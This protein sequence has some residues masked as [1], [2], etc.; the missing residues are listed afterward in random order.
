GKY[1]LVET[2]SL[3][4][5]KKLTEPVPFEITKGMTKALAI[6]VENEQLDK[7]S[8][9]ITKIDKDS[10]KVLEGVVFEVQ[11]EQGKV[12][13]EVKT[14]KDGKAKISDL[15][16]GKYKLVEKESLPG[17]KKLTDPVLF[18]IKKGMTEVLSLKIENEMVD[19]G[20]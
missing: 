19:T 18:E 9:E 3:P 13:T 15:S 16:V 5:Y 2:K 11:D 8:V 4:G 14:D 12:V 20:N 1:K 17:Y 10:Q 6:K 7:G